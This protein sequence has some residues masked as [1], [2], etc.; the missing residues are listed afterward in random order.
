MVEKI[1][2]RDTI[3]I[4]KKVHE[5]YKQ[6]TEGNDPVESPFKS[7]KDL[8]MWAA[9]LGFINGNRQPIEGKK[10]TIFRWAQFTP[11]IDIPLIKA[12]AL[13]SS[14]NIDVLIDRNDLLLVLEEYA[15]GGIHE[16]TMEI[17]EQPGQVLWNTVGLM[18][19]LNQNS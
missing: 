14:D 8:F 15:N 4:E 3:S 6:L 12:L 17:V 9:I 19:K 5:T 18:S 1:K 16:I 11:Q 7:M 13:A 2:G 10:E